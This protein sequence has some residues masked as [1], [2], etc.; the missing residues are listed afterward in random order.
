MKSK[1]SVALCALSLITCRAAV[2]DADHNGAGVA[3]P[4]EITRPNNSATMNSNLA[5]ASNAFGFDLFQQLRR[6]L[7]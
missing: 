6:G 3:Q 2:R 5:A 7:A 1:L 4:T